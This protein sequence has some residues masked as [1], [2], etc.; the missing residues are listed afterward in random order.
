MADNVCA[1]DHGVRQFVQCILVGM[2]VAVIQFMLTSTY[3]S[4]KLHN[5][6]YRDEVMWFMNDQFLPQML[7]DDR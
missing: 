2:P 4:I 6:Q 1:Q 5:E 7:R 3:Y